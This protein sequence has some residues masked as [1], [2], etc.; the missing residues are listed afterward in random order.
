MRPPTGGAGALASNA[1]STSPSG[2][3]S[4]ADHRE[5]RC[6]VLGRVVLRCVPALSPGMSIVCVK[7]L[8]ARRA[9]RGVVTRAVQQPEFPTRTGAL[10]RLG[11]SAR[12]LRSGLS[13]VDRRVS[14]QAHNTARSL[15]TCPH[16]RRC[17]AGAAGWL[18]GHGLGTGDRGCRQPSADEPGV[19]PTV[20][21]A[22]KPFTIGSPHL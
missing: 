7:T 10:A 3:R 17:R 2:L 14:R 4:G 20:I 19:T 13:T 5:P 12:A 18:E 6:V 21:Y 1:P 22:I 9:F 16:A 11:S 8:R 15:C